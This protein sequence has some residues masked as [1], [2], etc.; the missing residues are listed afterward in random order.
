MTPVAAKT[1]AVDAKTKA[2]KPKQVVVVR[3]K[4]AR[5]TIKACTRTSSGR[6]VIS[7]GPYNGYVGRNGVGSKREGDGRTPSGLYRLRGGFGYDK[8]PGVKFSWFKTDSRDRWVDDSRSRYYNLRMRTPVNGR[9]KSAEKLRI[10]AYK[11]AQVIGYNEKRT[12]GKGSAIFLHV[13]NGR[14]TAGC[15]SL[16]RTS[17]L[18]I[19]RW[20]K[21]GAYISIKRA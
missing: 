6:Y 10:P 15:V 17:L 5:A 1:C 16:S 19:L 12:P 3:S 11:Y 13:S 2:K 7:Y 21:P 4:G 20:Q 8:N 9:W 14:G 18:K